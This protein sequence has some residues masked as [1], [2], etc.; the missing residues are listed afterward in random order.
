MLKEVAEKRLAA[1]KEYT[2]LG[3][4]FKIAMRDLEIRGAGNLLG[5]E[6]HGHMEAVGYDLYCKMLNEAVK[7]AKGI[8]VAA[9]FDTSIDVDIDA[10]I[11][12]NYIP[13]EFQKL[14][15]YKRIAGIETKEESEEMTEELI[16]RFGDLP[17]SVENLLYIAKIKSL[18]HRVYFTEVAQKSDQIRFTLYEKAQI[19]VTKIPQF[20]ESYGTSLK[21]TADSKAPYFTYFLNKNSRE[22]NRNPMELLE[23][24]L[25]ASTELLLVEETETADVKK[26]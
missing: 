8:A 21:F 22:K 14:D 26:V 13:N 25:N 18:A 15:I 12:V 19:D 23:E 6:Q 1:I 10:Y 2:E 9:N 16:D 4:G 24:F 17:K 20:V 7:E 5:A 3:S 11:P